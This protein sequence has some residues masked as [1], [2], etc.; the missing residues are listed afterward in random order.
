MNTGWIVAACAGSAAVS[1]CLAVLILSKRERRRRDRD[2]ATLASIATQLTST[3]GEEFFNSL[4]LHLCHEL[5]V[6]YAIIAELDDVEGKRARTVALVADGTLKPPMTYALDGTPC[7]NVFAKEVCVYP[8]RIAAH[9]PKDHLLVQMGAEGYVG[10]PLITSSNEVI[11]IAALLNRKPFRE[12]ARVEAGLR[13]FSARAASELD[14]RRA[15]RRLAEERNRANHYLEAVQAILVAL[16]SRGRVTM[17]NPKGC[18]VLGYEAEELLGKPWFESCLPQPEGVRDVFPI[19]GMLMSGKVQGADYFENP[20]VTKSGARRVIAWHNTL[21]HDER[22][23]IVG[24]LSAGEDVTERREA[25]QLRLEKLNAE[26]ASRAKSTFLANMSHEIRTPMNAILGFTQLLHGD[27]ELTPRLRGHVEVIHRNGEHLLSLINSI[28]ELSKIEAGRVTLSQQDFNLRGLV[29]DIQSLFSLRVAEKQLSFRL[30]IASSVPTVIHGDPVKIRQILS[31]LVA[32]AVKFTARG[33]VVLEVTTQDSGGDDLELRIRITDTGCGIPA[34]ELPRLFRAFEQT[35]T[36]RR[37][38]QGSGLGL[39]ISR[40][41]AR[42]HGGDITVESDPGE[43]SVFDI[44][45][46]VRR[47]HVT[48]RAS[49]GSQA[50]WMR[51]PSHAGVVTALIVD[52]VPD[53]RAFLKRA[54]TDSGYQCREADTGRAAVEACRR[55]MPRVILMDLLMP[56]LDGDKAIAE[57]RALPEGGRPF[58]VAL[59]ASVLDDRH[60]NLDHIGANAFLG[61]PFRLEALLAKIADGVKT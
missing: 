40:E 2:Q 55:E 16:D 60:A 36:G 37:I 50:G 47:T 58:I 45:L 13:I 44:V 49:N 15:E 43:G 52:D 7:Q 10:I 48:P 12:T 3:S 9:F 11:G 31:N 30:D 1:A 39:A 4:A 14:R 59:S 57:I 32:N 22:G 19:F 8:S 28:L 51:A 26:A 5:H 29:N 18:Q 56:E 42:L 53:N 6:D 25:E 38:G 23:H 33:G 35:D 17:I 41:Y 21:L 46:R 20:V 24:T 27:A 54:L 34:A 61:K